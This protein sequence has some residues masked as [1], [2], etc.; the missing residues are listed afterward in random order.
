MRGAQDENARK[1]KP[2]NEPQV[3]PPVGPRSVQEAREFWLGA[4]S[5]R[6]LANR[7]EQMRCSFLLRLD[8]ADRRKLEQV[9]HHRAAELPHAAMMLL[10]AAEAASA[11]ARP[12]R[13]ISR[14]D[15]LRRPDGNG[16]GIVRPKEL[17]YRNSASGRGV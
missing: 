10:W 6:A 16:T 1:K 2:D 15:P 13:Q 14:D 3:E 17:N 11:I 7:R 8:E 12:A 5:G 4:V 9:S